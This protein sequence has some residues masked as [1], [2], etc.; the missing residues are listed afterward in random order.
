[1]VLSGGL[2]NINGYFKFS[3][4]LFVIK[5]KLFVAGYFFKRFLQNKNFIELILILRRL[6]Y[7]VGKIEHNKFAKIG[8]NTRIDMYIPGFPSKAFYTAC[9]KFSV[10]GEKLP[11]TTALISVTSACSYHCEHCYQKYDV[12]K[13]VDLGELITVVKNLQDKGIA[14]FNIE[15][16]E[17]F[18]A[19]DRLLS[20]CQNIDDRSEIWVNSTGNEITKEKLLQLKETSLKVIMF[21]LHSHKPDEIN[22]FMGDDNAWKNLKNGIKLC[23]EVRIPVAFNSC[24][25]L[26]DFKNGNFE[27][28]ML[29]AKELGGVLIQI[30]KPKPSGGWL[31]SGVEEY[32]V[33]DFAMIK[34]KVNLYNQCKKYADYPAI[35][36]QIMEEDSNLFGCTAGGTDRFYINAKGDLQ[37]CEFLNISFGNIAIDDFDEIYN[38]MR[39]AFEIPQTCIAC[40]KFSTDI[41][42]IHQENNLK[43]LPLNPEL[44]AEVIDKIKFD[45][46][47]ELYAKIEKKMTKRIIK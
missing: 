15:G 32:S 8:K 30:I 7:F 17:P 12:G 21:S 9:Q 1:M 4:K 31:E 20:V 25:P 42:K 11:C 13:D 3:K 26:V 29:L 14:F 39:K 2:M 37:P 18:L 38:K 24:L 23:H 33:A 27:K 10:F 34:D 22:K 46:P 28:V 36:A 35:S 5:V 6:N 45:Q 16:G 41:R 43:T 44:S 40:E 19:F 47:T